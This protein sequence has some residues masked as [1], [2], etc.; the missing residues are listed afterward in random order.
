MFPET[1]QPLFT[2][3]TFTEDQII[4]A[5]LLSEAAYKRSD[6]QTKADGW[7]GVLGLEA[8]LTGVT[9]AQGHYFYG[10][11]AVFI[12]TG[13]DGKTLT[14]AARGTD[15]DDPI[16]DVTTYWSLDP[17]RLTEQYFND[18]KAVVTAALDH[19]KGNGIETVTVTGH[20]LGG[21][22]VGGFFDWLTDDSGYD[23]ADS[24][25]AFSGIGFASPAA[26]HVE[27]DRMMELSYMNDLI[28]GIASPDVAAQEVGNLYYSVNG[29]SV[30]PDYDG[31]STAYF[32]ELLQAYT[33]P[34]HDIARWPETLKALVDSPVY[35]AV[36]RDDLVIIDKNDWPVSVDA[37]TLL[38]GA[39]RDHLE[40]SSVVGILGDT[41]GDT[42]F[43]SGKSDIIDGRGGDDTLSG[44]GG[45]DALY[46]GAG[47]DVMR[48]GGGTDAFH[49]GEGHDTLRDW[50][51][52]EQ[53]VFE[54]LDET[55]DSLAGLKQLA[56]QESAEVSHHWWSTTKIAF[57]DSESL[58]LNGVSPWEWDSAMA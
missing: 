20:S 16:N 43:G 7:T 18:L 36:D 34:A 8:G 39:A 47:N 15:V 31:G 12:A 26:G 58:T 28:S 45:N 3:D 25:L 48:G 14:I 17:D 57:S 49:V 55:V 40:T 2:R 51:D 44:L 11:A 9:G 46:G 5:S 21:S 19:A 53:I 29:G 54:T 35:K 30:A 1:S 38:N 41:K 42:I 22:F 32:S 50:R 33:S 23:T 4:T 10:S 56:A 37:I 27:D 6:W 13:D 24:G 52:G